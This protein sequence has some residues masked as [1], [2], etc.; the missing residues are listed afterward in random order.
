MMKYVQDI[1][2]NYKRWT[3]KSFR[4]PFVLVFSLLQPIV[5]LILFSQ[6]FG[7]VATQAIPDVT[8][9]TY[10]V[11][12]IVIQVSLASAA[13]SGIGFV[14]DIEEGMYEKIQVSPMRQGAV[15]IGKTLA[16]QTRI[17]VQISIILGLGVLM[18]AT[19]GTGLPGVLA[20]ILLGM[21]FSLWFVGFTNTI[22]VYTE[23]QEST[24]IA[25]NFLQ[26]PMLFLSSAFLPT[27]ELPVW[28][29]S[30]ATYNPVTYGVDATRSVML[31]T[32]VQ[33]ALP[34]VTN[35]LIVLGLLATAFG[36]LA[37]TALKRSSNKTK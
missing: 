32:T 17:A 5:F 34:V 31:E 27:E 14:N 24:I 20:I 36:V 26:F 12:A 4:N 29:Q 11:P 33:G 3:L 15:F 2:V 23:D 22:A 7:G 37:V 18:G 25:A 19:I 30:I 21:L 8:Y 6:V 9:I 13:T 35:S 28:I 10:L 16:E 1:I